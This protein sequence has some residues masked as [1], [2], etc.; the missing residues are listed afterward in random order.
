[1]SD[2]QVGK[3]RDPRMSAIAAKKGYALEGTAQLFEVSFF[4]AFDYILAADRDVLYW[5]NFFAR[6]AQDKAKLFLITAFSEKYLEQDI[7]DPY[8]GSGEHF[9]EVLE[10]LEDACRGIFKRL[11]PT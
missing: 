7:P 11:Y 3:P 10:M 6:N 1:M 8:Y 5:L 9:D 4:D 2:R